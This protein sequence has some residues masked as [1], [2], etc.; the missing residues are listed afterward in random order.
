[1]DPHYVDVSWFDQGELLP[2]VDSNGV[3]AVETFDNNILEVNMYN[4]IHEGYWHDFNPHLV[5]Q[6]EE[7]STTSV[8]TPKAKKFYALL[9]EANE[10][11]YPGSET[12][13]LE[14]LVEMFQAKK[15]INSSGLSY[16]KINAC[17]N[18]CM[19][20]WE[21]HS[22]DT[23]YPI[24][25]ANR[26]KPNDSRIGKKST[27]VPEKVLCYF[28]IGSRL[29]RLSMSRYTVESMICHSEKRTKD[30][31]LRHPPDSPAWD[32]LDNSY[33]DFARECRNVRLGL[34]SD[35]FNPFGWMTNGHSVDV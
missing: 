32:H 11:L 30:G 27:K 1:M 12:K 31:V 22:K 25:G 15:L 4:L 19:L 17:L 9:D 35:G 13:T 7:S 10:V 16:E 5:Q 34:A 33:S 3:D 14:F 6:E 21:T 26:Y 2:S 20:F 29:Q 24:C 28:P 18:N 8:L 23:F